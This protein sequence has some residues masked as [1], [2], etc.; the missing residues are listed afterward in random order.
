MLLA[1]LM[2]AA[3][4]PVRFRSGSLAAEQRDALLSG[5]VIDAAA[6]MAQID[7]ALRPTT[8]VEA[9][10]GPLPTAEQL[11]VLASMPDVVDRSVRLVGDRV[12]RATAHLA[13]ALRA[14]EVQVPD[15]ITVL[16]DLEATEHTWVQVASGPEWVD[17][18]PT[19][20]QATAGLVHAEP[21]GGPLD[22]LPDELR[23][24]IEFVVTIESLKGGGLS[25]SAVIEQSAFADELAGRP[26][27]LSHEKPDGLKGLGLALESALAGGIRYQPILSLDEVTL[28]GIE[29]LTFG[30][31]GGPFGETNAS[32][33]SDGEAT[34]EW[35]D[36]RVI[37]PDR[38]LWHAA[39][40]S[41]G[42][43]TPHGRAGPS[44]WRPSNRS[45]SSTSTTSSPM[46]T[47]PSASCISCPWPRAR[48]ASI[49]SSMTARPRPTQTCS[50][51]TRPRSISSAT[52]CR[53][54]WACHAGI[55]PSSTPPTWSPMT[56][57]SGQVR[58]A[59]A[60]RGS[61]WQSICLSAARGAPR[62]WDHLHPRPQG[63][64]RVCS[65][66]RPSG[67]RPAM[68]CRGR[69]FRILRVASVGAVF[70]AADAQ[71]VRTLVLRQ[72]SDAD[73]LPLAPDVVGR[74]KAGLQRGWVAVIPERPVQLHGR[75]RIGWWLI[76][77]AT[78]EAVDVFEDGRSSAMT[79]ESFLYNRIAFWVR[80][81]VCLGLT[82]KEVKTLAKLLTGDYEGFVV[83]VA[84]GY[85][86]HYLL[87]GHC[88]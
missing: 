66:T 16:P 56:S 20:P 53:E 22:A 77:P 64:W 8:P 58:R 38:D 15:G 76:D 51:R 25:Q 84:I 39:P 82:I 86:L 33:V 10:A 34:A 35:L 47:C 17:L 49:V 9:Q 46:S 85:P 52:H 54:R 88:H 7:D 4:I 70:E 80:R 61:T 73:T 19:M 75:D 78:G 44:T 13:E 48:R 81:F 71:G 12:D 27:S 72:A 40:S 14:A 55:G 32:P 23:H 69:P 50:R 1:S 26:I 45:N 74:L 79:E 67:S 63:S 2:V 36:V 28:V 62:S 30:A 60:R 3:A 21:T 43:A 65:N 57:A 31:G 87:G 11:A 24:R 18:D 6:A 68:G 29:P 41:I 37:S 83:G 5:A 42:S 59:L